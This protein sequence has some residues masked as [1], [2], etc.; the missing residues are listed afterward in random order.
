MIH[1]LA[2]GHWPLVIWLNDWICPQLYMI[3]VLLE[4]WQKLRRFTYI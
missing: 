4:N 2:I 1:P 3:C